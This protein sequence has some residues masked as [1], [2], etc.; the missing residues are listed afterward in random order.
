[1]TRTIA[2]RFNRFVLY[3]SNVY[4]SPLYDERGFGE[5]LDTR[6][7]TQNFYFDLVR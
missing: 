7:L 3:S 5:T 6:R 2:M 4:R 1:M